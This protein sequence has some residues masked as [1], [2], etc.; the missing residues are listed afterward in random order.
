[1]R[2]AVLLV[3]AFLVKSTR[4]EV[5]QSS[6]HGE[7][8]AAP[9]L[10]AGLA[11]IVGNTDGG[12]KEGSTIGVGALIGN[13]EGAGVGEIDDIASDASDASGI[14][15]F[16]LAGGDERAGLGDI[17]ISGGL[18]AQS[19]NGVDA[20]VGII[21][22]SGGV[23]TA[24]GTSPSHAVGSS[25]V[26][27][28]SSGAGGLSLPNKTAVHLAPPP[29]VQTAARARPF[30]TKKT[31]LAILKTAGAK[32][33]G[34]GASGAAAGVVQVR[35]QQQ[36]PARFRARCLLAPARRRSH[37][38]HLSYAVSPLLPARPL[39]FVL[40]LFRPAS[41]SRSQVVSMMWLRTIMNYQYRYGLTARQAARALWLQ[42][43]CRPFAGCT[44]VV[45]NPRRIC[46][47]MPFLLLHVFLFFT[48]PCAPRRTHSCY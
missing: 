17:D 27:S 21:E 33:L 10:G 31:P 4:S 13:S 43:I 26:L 15:A 20:G 42:V 37:A 45:S 25:R 23:D 39:C 35:G 48:Q 9:G 8:V 1:M 41:L 47:T 24:V 12:N 22:A 32:A 38:A 34:G 7:A 30:P 28:S 46:K 5:N 3:A 2:F 29:R 11:S 44:C 19:G 18:G 16:A 14:G 40:L 36:R 6:E